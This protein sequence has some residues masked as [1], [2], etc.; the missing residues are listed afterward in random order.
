MQHLLML[1]KIYYR[2]S[3][4]VLH[5]DLENKTLNKTI[6]LVCKIFFKKLY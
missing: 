3:F 6:K 5:F 1:E 4:L 2:I